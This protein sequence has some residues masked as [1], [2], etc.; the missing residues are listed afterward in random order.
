LHQFLVSFS[1]ITNLNG[2]RVDIS[3]NTEYPFGRTLT[4][5]MTSESDFD[6]YI[7]VPSWVSNGSYVQYN[8]YKSPFTPNE[9]GHFHAKVT[10]GSSQLT[11][12]LDYSM[13]VESQ[14]STN[15]VSVYYGPLLYSLDIA[16]NETIG[17]A[18]NWTDR[19]PLPPDQ[20]IPE[21]HDHFL[22]PQSNLSWRIGVDPSQIKVDDQSSSN[23]LP[24]P[25][26]AAGA[27]PVELY[28]AAS[29]IDWPITT[30]TAALPPDPATP[31]GDPF[32]AKLVP[33]GT[34]KL[35]MAELPV[36]SLPQ[37]N[38]TWRP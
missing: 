8:Q 22:V 33:Y 2:Q 31:I 23:P 10:K 32:Y 3:C 29:H 34:A 9:D 35:H 13:R 12:S 36:L 7:R 5:S 28:I 30:D 27:S 20:V 6:F 4:Y 11:V 15:S 19:T 1:L 38:F 24:N 17:P 37:L 25:I 21:V 18:L 26:F 16:Y 14:N